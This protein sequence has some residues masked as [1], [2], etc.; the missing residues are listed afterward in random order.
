MLSFALSF[1]LY[2][3]S[4]LEK[5]DE[6]TVDNATV[7]KST[8]RRHNTLRERHDTEREQNRSSLFF[9]F[10]FSPLF[11]FLGSLSLSLFLLKAKS[12]EDTFHFGL[13]LETRARVGRERERESK[14]NRERLSRVV[15]FRVERRPN[16]RREL[17]SHSSRSACSPE[18]RCCGT[19]PRNTTT[20]TTT[21]DL[22]MVSRK[23]KRC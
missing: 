19:G 2:K 11:F 6:K 10:V 23:R 4:L 12:E 15:C 18:R 9:L 3:R 17:Q 20:T 16:A 1:V 13:E 8:P 5:S 22:M 14:N 7:I 21:T